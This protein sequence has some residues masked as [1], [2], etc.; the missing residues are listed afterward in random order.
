M[1][2]KKLTFAKLFVCLRKCFTIFIIENF[3]QNFKQ[4]YLK[5]NENDVKNKEEN[6]DAKM[7][8]EEST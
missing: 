7:S 4:H 8:C 5:I 2:T 1:Q 3:G 6:K